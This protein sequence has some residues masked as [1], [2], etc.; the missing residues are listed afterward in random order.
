MENYNAE[1]IYKHGD[2]CIFNGVV[3]RATCSG[4]AMQ[5]IAPDKNSIG[6][7]WLVDDDDDEAQGVVNGLNP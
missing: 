4:A 7:F 6:T 1:E 5:Y 2:K 3:Y